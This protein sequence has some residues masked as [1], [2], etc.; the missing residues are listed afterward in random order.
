MIH[1][2]HWLIKHSNR[3]IAGSHCC[4]ANVLHC[5]C[6][7]DFHMFIEGKRVQKTVSY[8]FPLKLILIDSSTVQ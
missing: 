8:I 6:A 3:S 2:K 1:F 5:N 4:V 7:A